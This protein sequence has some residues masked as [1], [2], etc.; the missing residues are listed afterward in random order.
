MPRCQGTHV[1]PWVEDGIHAYAVAQQGAAGLPFRRID[2]DDGQGFVGEIGE[3][4]AH[5]FIDQ[6][7][8]P[9]TTGTGDPQDR[10]RFF[11][12]FQPDF[13]KKQP[14]LFGVVFRGR[15]QPG[16]FPVIFVAYFIKFI[17]LLIPNRKITL[18]KQIVDHPL[19]RHLAPVV[20]RIDAGNAILM[21]FAYLIRKDYTAAAA[22]NLHMAAIP[23]PEKIVHVF[24]ILHMAALV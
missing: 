17:N 4:P 23:F 21:K 11:G 18:L 16:N 14:A 2:G 1:H 15:D 20:G 8:F 12:C 19:E 5:N 13:I 9:G 3:K 6:R 24:K 22:E 7:R 10:D